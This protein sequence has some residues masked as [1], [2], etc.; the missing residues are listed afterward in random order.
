[1]I[2]KFAEIPYDIKKM[3][4]EKC[5]ETN[6]GPFSLIPDFKKFKASLKKTVIK[7]SKY[8]II[9]ITLF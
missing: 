6:A 1:M 5:L 8:D 4:A 9:C 2:L 3:I 7:E